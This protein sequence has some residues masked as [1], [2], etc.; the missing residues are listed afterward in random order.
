MKTERVIHM[1]TVL[2]KL[3][4][5]ED[6]SSYDLYLRTM[7]KDHVG[8]FENV[9]GIDTHS[10]SYAIAAMLCECNVEL[11][12][13]NEKRSGTATQARVIKNVIKH[14]NAVIRPN[15][16]YIISD[17][18]QDKQIVCDGMRV[19]LFS[20][21]CRSVPIATEVEYSQGKPE[22]FLKFIHEY[23]EFRSTELE[24]PSR[25]QLV[26]YLKQKKA[27]LKACKDK[28]DSTKVVYNF[29]PG[30]PAVSVEYLIDAI[31]AAPDSKCY[32]VDNGHTPIPFSPLLFVCDRAVSLL[33]P[34]RKNSAL[35]DI[36][37]VL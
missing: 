16:S 35:P 29:G 4:S 12:R 17:R 1:L 36:K 34:I 15:V 32:T 8:N 31:D 24:I 22:T 14:I 11:A 21:I 28:Y 19:F 26:A 9:C 10:I 3:F 30:L 37:T 33:M 7:Q 2:T 6:R 27:T 18:G 20:D 13:E 5:E 25:T 23:S